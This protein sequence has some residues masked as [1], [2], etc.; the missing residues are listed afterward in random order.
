VSSFE[1]GSSGSFTHV[2][3]DL[4]VSAPSLLRLQ[5]R[6]VVFPVSAVLYMCNICRTLWDR[7]LQPSP[8]VISKAFSHP[9]L[10]TPTVTGGVSFF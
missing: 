3:N 7:I 4:S 5:P 2:A 8:T 9:Y 6:L 10:T 1:M